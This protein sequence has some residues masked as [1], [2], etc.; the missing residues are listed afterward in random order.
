MRD[1]W[2]EVGG[3]DTSYTA[4]WSSTIPRVD[5]PQLRAAHE[6]Q[7]SRGST[8]AHVREIV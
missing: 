4:D 8:F 7:A 6:R 1:R 5:D 3:K 2:N